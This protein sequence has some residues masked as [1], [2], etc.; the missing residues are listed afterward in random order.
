VFRGAITDCVTGGLYLE[1]WS[2]ERLPVAGSAAGVVDRVTHRGKRTAP[3]ALIPPIR[4]ASEKHIVSGR[5]HE[6]R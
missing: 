2:A 1:R 3:V 4:Q 6:V 5:P